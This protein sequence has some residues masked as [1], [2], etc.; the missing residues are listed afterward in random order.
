M[1]VA[2][3]ER[4]AGRSASAAGTMPLSVEDVRPFCASQSAGNVRVPFASV[5]VRP[6]SPLTSRFTRLAMLPD[7]SCGQANH[8]VPLGEALT[9]SS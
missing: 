2:F 5:C 3:P 4:H 1:R 7:S 9:S 6:K 8:A